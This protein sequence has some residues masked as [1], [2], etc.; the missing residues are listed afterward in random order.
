MPV[1]EWTPEPHPSSLNLLAR[2]AVTYA[3]RPAKVASAVRHSIPVLGRLPSA[4][5]RL[6][7]IGHP[8]EEGLLGGV[9]HT[10]FN[11]RTDSSRNF[12]GRAYDLPSVLAA[13]KLVP[14]ATVND[15]VISAI[16]GALR[17]YLLD[18]GEL[19]ESS[20]VTVIAMAEHS[21]GQRGANQIA[22]ARASLGTN[23]A[24]PV[25]R[26]RAVH[27]SSAPSKA[28]IEAVGPRSFIEYAEFLPGALLVPVIRLARA[29]NLGKYF[30][31][32]WFAN[33]YVTTLRGPQFPI[34]FIGAKMFASYSFT[35]FTQGNG[36][37]HSAL[38]YCGR[39]L[40]SING[41]PVVLPDIEHYGDCMD[42][43]F[44]ELISEAR[45]LA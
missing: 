25:A 20:L 43:S 16:G 22:V 10:R 24:D 6:M 17:R 19:P 7:P 40:V 39:V 42:A 32:S 30:P 1:K 23:V 26:L 2:S 4:M 12:D 3:R 5:I 44:A 14:G 37:M 41:C 15:V 9:P 27:E 11:D 31:S 21:A 38:S 28:F 33:T 45:A 29:A 34:Y 18:K 35:P 36:L 8:I 13:R